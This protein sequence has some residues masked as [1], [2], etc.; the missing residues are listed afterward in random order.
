MSRPYQD[1][2]KEIRDQI[3]LIWKETPNLR[4]L[5]DFVKGMAAQIIS[6]IKHPEKIGHIG[7]IT[8]CGYLEGGLYVAVNF[9]DPASNTL[10]QIFFL[11]EVRFLREKQ[12]VENKE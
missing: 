8:S 12:V 11:P 2:N 3:N 1:Y 10:S 9:S 6:S 4:V 7:M 5:S